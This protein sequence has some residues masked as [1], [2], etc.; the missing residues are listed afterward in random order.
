MM[1]IIRGHLP[2]FLRGQL[3]LGV[4]AKR[5]KFQQQSHP[6]GLAKAAD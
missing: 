2:G 1:G 4:S 5:S 6:F 3:I